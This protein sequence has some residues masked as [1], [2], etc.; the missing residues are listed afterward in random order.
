MGEQKSEIRSSKSETSNLTPG[1][2]KPETHLSHFSL[3]TRHSSLDTQ[4]SALVPTLTSLPL[5]D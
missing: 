4:H 5:L 3:D 2:P 1:P